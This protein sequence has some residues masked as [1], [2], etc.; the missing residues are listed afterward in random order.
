M[1]DESGNTAG[2]EVETIDM[3]IGNCSRS[4]G[5]AASEHVHHTPRGVV[6]VRST[7]PP[8]VIFSFKNR[9]RDVKSTLRPALGDDRAA[10][11]G[12][13]VYPEITLTGVADVALA[14]TCS[15]RR[16]FDMGGKNEV[17]RER[18]RSGKWLWPV[19]CAGKLQSRRRRDQRFGIGTSSGEGGGRFEFK[20]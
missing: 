12:F 13:Q 3:G 17:W 18:C 8:P 19:D 11:S 7:T 6:R 16:V 9:D 20:I 2:H 4:S 14:L 10:Q 1:R 15:E 5:D